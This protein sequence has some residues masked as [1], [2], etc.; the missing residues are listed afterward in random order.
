MSHERL[1]SQ[2]EI[3]VRELS[4]TDFGLATPLELYGMLRELAEDGGINPSDALYVGLDTYYD[5]PLRDGFNDRTSTWAFT[6]AEYQQAAM[7]DQKF[8]S[9]STDSPIFYA[10]KSSQPT[11]LV[12]DGAQFNNAL[13]NIRT[14]DTD[15]MNWDDAT[16]SD[17]EYQVKPGISFGDT[18]VA[19]LRVV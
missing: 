9:H 1:S 8:S 15:A 10:A 17:L 2:K 14:H 6:D 16:C 13:G 18:L 19:A 4:E 5:D 7:S 3:S 12:F 11:V